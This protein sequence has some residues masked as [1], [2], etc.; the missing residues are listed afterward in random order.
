MNG[1]ASYARFKSAKL[2]KCYSIM[3]MQ[4]P[5]VSDQLKTFR[6]PQRT[7]GVK[8]SFRLFWFDIRAWL[9]YAESKDLA[10]C[11]LFIG[12]SLH[13]RDRI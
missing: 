8:K 5:H 12:Y 10:F 6:F 1:Y 11:H 3:D 2:Y 13:G 7:F 4:V 9:H